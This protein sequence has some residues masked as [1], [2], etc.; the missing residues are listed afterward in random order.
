MNDLLMRLLGVPAD[1]MPEG[2]TSEFLLSGGPRSWGVF[3]LIGV[4]IAGVLGIFYIYRREISTCPRPARITLAV[5]RSLIVLLLVLVALGPAVVFTK[6]HVIDPFIVL[7]LDRS[8]SMNEPDRYLD[9][10]AIAPVVKATGLDAETIRE[11]KPSRAQLVHTLFTKND[12]R[13]V[14][15][16]A[17]VGKLRIIH[18]AGS[19]EIKETKP[20]YVPVARQNESSPI[21]SDEVVLPRLKAVFYVAAITVVA[22]AIWAFVA[23]RALVAL[24]GAVPLVVAFLSLTIFLE[25][26]PDH[27]PLRLLGLSVVDDM[28]GGKETTAQQ[29]KLREQEQLQRQEKE[30]DAQLPDLVAD[31]RTTNLGR[32]IRKAL[33]SESSGQIAALVLVGDGRNTAGG[34]D[35]L[36]AA[37]EA[38]EAN[39]PIFTVG[40]GD[41]SRERRLDVVGVYADDRVW[42]GDPFEIRTVIRSKDFPAD[43]VNVQLW[44]RSAGQTEGGKLIKEETVAALSG[45]AQ[46]TVVFRYEPKQDGEFQY[47][48]KLVGV[49][50]PRVEGKLED[51]AP[52]TVLQERARVLLVS[53]SPTWE[54]RLVQVLLKRDPTIDLSCW[55]QSIRDMP[56]E[57][58]TRIDQLPV[59][60]QEMASYD[61]ILLLDPN[62]EEFALS[63]GS[64]N[65]WDESL[66]EFLSDGGGVLYMAGPKYSARFL[67]G[68][69]TGGITDILPIRIGDRASLEIAIHTDKYTLPYRFRPVAANVDH[70]VMRFDTDSDVTLARWQKMPKMYWH[71]PISGG[72]KTTGRVLLEHN[73]PRFANSD[74]FRPLLVTGQ[75]GAGRT[76]YMGFNGTW[77]WRRLGR[78]SEFFTRYW[79]QSVRYLVEGRL[80][81]SQKRGSIEIPRDKYSVGD[82]FTM[83]AR[84]KSPQGLPLSDP[85]VI[86]Q[87]HVH[88]EKTTV[89]QFTLRAEADKPGVYK[90]EIDV[91]RQGTNFVS[92]ALAGKKTGRQVELKS[93]NFKV[94]MTDIE[95]ENRQLNKQL[96]RDV[97][98][99]ASEQYGSRY[100]EIDQLDRLAAAIRDRT[101]VKAIPGRPVDL[102]DTN[103][104]VFLL[105]LLL[106][107]EWGARKRFKLM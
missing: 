67:S 73:S 40:V 70:P 14:R 27:R 22:L 60:A 78:D 46:K 75:Y 81:G 45:D 51:F 24:V 85:M 87:L 48:I 76:V 28:L 21:A 7:A 53:G 26:N 63:A 23:S 39:V 11:Q 25:T 80:L 65:R 62:P 58:N 86:A 68:H 10:D 83:T 91:R 35:Y 31:G 32:A 88:G 9:D 64:L 52:V 94:E 17:A 8:K 19:A 89:G 92:I 101:E 4:V 37:D 69:A 41:M 56:Q 77:R 97:A 72:A 43:S 42:R 93:K 84:L 3:L 16:L 99:R 20:R 55:L 47:W 82:R 105:A 38:N 66:K 13:L 71:F 44:E 54:Y 49:T 50:D 74:G 12:G 5:L 79:I 15:Q 104:F 102:W 29:R 30:F 100:F 90:G 96:L 107:I 103:R 36:K 34:E 57:G 98:E 33:E 59:T 18:Y 2:A 1:R 95:L 106:T 6:K 61:V